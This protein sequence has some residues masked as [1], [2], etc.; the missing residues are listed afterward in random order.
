VSKKG[1]LEN[2]VM[3]LATQQQQ[4][5]KTQEQFMAEEKQFRI[6]QRQTNAKHDQSIQRLEVQVGQL[7]KELSGRKQGEFPAQ[8]IPNP[9]GHQQLQAVTVLNSGKEIGTNATT[10]SQISKMRVYPP[11]PFLQRL[12]KPKTEV[13]SQVPPH[14]ATT[15]KVSEMEKVNAPPFPQSLVKPKKENKLLDIFEI[16]RKVQINIPLLDAIKQIP[17]YSK[18]LKYF[19]TNKRRFKEHET[20]ALTEEVSAVLLR[21]FAG[22]QGTTSKD[23]IHVPIGPVTRARAKKFKD[24]F[25]G[26]IQEL[27]AQ[28]NS[29]RPIEH[30]PQRQQRIVTLIQ[31]LEG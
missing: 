10:Q 7:A 6:E 19:C 28:A 22:D 3:Q 31:V 12:V 26:L 15:S 24:V 20:M 30:D 1:Y 8:T 13:K 29:W 25:N 2:L 9:E 21:K 14:E 11:P 23:L 27:W 4:M 16:L 5:L 18:F 17:S